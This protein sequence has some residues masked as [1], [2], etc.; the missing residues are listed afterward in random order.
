MIQRFTDRGRAQHGRG[1]GRRL[2]GAVAVL[3]LLVAATSACS[4]AA[5]ARPDLGRVAIPSAPGAP[6]VPTA[7]PGHAQLVAMGDAVHL[8]LGAQQGQITATGPDL[9][10]PAPAP[11]AAPAAQSQGSITVT[12][13]VPAG[14]E[15]LS[16]DALAVS[17][18]LGHAVQ[19]TADAAS[20]TAGPGHDAVLHLAGTFAAGHSTLTWS[21]AGKPLA[22]WDFEVELD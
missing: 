21:N 2:P 11:G 18:E 17:D 10:L 13:R 12:L 8:D 3:G 9:A 6:I 15:V 20:A 14:S 1:L 22:T 16:G 19:V 4:S 5:P 7:S